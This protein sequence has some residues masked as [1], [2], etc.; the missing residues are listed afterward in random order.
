MQNLT[1]KEGAFINRV[2][3]QPTHFHKGRH[4]GVKPKTAR[5]S[6]NRIGCSMESSSRGL[7]VEQ[8]QT[9]SGADGEVGV[10]HI[11]LAGC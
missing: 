5:S 8:L 4:L 7:Y 1:G 2:N 6:N 3:K 9:F 11:A 10:F